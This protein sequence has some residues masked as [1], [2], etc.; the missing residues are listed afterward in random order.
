MATTSEQTLQREADGCVVIMEKLLESHP[1]AWSPPGQCL[2]RAE[3]TLRK[4]GVEE[5]FVQSISRALSKGRG[6]E[7]NVFLMGPTNCAKSFFLKPLRLSFSVYRIPDDGSHKLET[8]LE[9]ELMFLNDFEWVPELESWMRWGYFKNFLE[10][11]P[12]EVATAKDEG[13]Q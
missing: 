13:W 3:D 5:D 1:C 9:K 7:N 11:E 8:L 10:G 4:N 12:I 6:K 2:R